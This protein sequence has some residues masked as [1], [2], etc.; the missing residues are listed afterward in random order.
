MVARMTPHSSQD[1]DAYR[2]VEEQA[3]AQAADPLPKLRR[4]LEVRGLLDAESD[5]WMRES[6]TA[7]VEAA[8]QKAFAQPEADASRARHWLYA[9]D[10]PHPYLD[11]LER[12]GS[13]TREADV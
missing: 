11:E 4:E 5:R 2:T 6:I 12:Q 3:A 13:P 8:E 10:S 9:G 7:E 1:D